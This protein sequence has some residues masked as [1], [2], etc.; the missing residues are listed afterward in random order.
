MSAAA[1][2]VLYTIPISHYC[3]KARWALDR[4][5]IPYRERAH[6][7]VIHRFVAMRVGRSKTMPVLARSDGGVLTESEDI[8]A[9]ADTRAPADARLYPDDPA[10]RDE[11]RALERDFDDRLGPHGRRW[12]YFRL[13]KSR[14]LAVR[15][16]CTGVPDWE[17][18]LLPRRL[19]ADD[20]SDRPRARHHAR[21]RDRVRGRRPRRCST[22]S[23]N[24]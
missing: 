8:L 19:S 16:G 18:R 15:Y 11:V 6:V 2:D 3:E 13:R 4:S 14:D 23:T 21:D 5:G 24:A 10:E 9:Y 17:R 20:R 1:P 12:M 7:Q 22:R